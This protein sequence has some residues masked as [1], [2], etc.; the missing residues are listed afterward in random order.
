M[1]GFYFFEAGW[2]LNELKWYRYNI[3]IAFLA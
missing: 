1:D 2:I 3:A